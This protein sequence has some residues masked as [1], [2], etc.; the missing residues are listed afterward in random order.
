METLVVLLVGLVALAAAINPYGVL[1][2]VLGLVWGRG[3]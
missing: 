3:R 2:E 1:A